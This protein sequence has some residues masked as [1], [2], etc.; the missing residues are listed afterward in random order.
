MFISNLDIY[1]FVKDY[2]EDSRELTVDEMKQLS[3][4]WAEKR[5][6]SLIELEKRKEEEA[7]AQ[8]EMWRRVKEELANDSN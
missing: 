6:N 5:R 8:K 3:S 4:D 1:K 2:Y 7:E